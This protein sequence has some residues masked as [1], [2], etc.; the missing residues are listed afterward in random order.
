MPSGRRVLPHDRAFKCSPGFAF[1][2]PVYSEKFLKLIHTLIGMRGAACLNFELSDVETV[3]YLVHLPWFGPVPPDVV[4][5]VVVSVMDLIESLEGS[6][7]YWTLSNWGSTPYIK[8]MDDDRITSLIEGVDSLIL[9]HA[10][11]DLLGE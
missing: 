9:E 11:R 1:H 5:A 10:P 2:T 3:S 8:G 4:R 6:S 7:D